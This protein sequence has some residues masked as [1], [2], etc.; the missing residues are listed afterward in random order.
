MKNKKVLKAFF[1]IT[2][3]GLVIIV[4]IGIS[5]LIGLQFNKWFNTT[6][7]FLIWIMMGIISAFSS[8]Y[9]L[10]NSFYKKDKKREDEELM[11]YQNLQKE[12]KRNIKDD[13]DK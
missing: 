7:W 8:V 12:Y 3:I 11:Y 4:N 9:N 5:A 1:L 10:T 13:K 6:I 2:Q